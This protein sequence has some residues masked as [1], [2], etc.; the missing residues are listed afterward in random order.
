MDRT[1]EAIDL[2]KKRYGKIPQILGLSVI[3]F[4]EK[5]NVFFYST[6]EKVLKAY[7]TQDTIL[8]WLLT[9]FM[10]PVV[11]VTF[12]GL[13]L[14]F[15]YEDTSHP[16]FLAI[17]AFYAVYMVFLGILLIRVNR[18]ERF[19]KLGRNIICLKCSANK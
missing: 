19:V 5:Q 17:Y 13:M 12:I 14:L 11:F 2:F 8:N 7:K 3:S 4:D 10:W 16:L 15:K 9:W 6:S 1:N 18:T